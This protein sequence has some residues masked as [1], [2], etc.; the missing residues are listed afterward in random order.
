MMVGDILKYMPTATVGKVTD[1]RDRD[2][3][4]WVKLDNTN[5]YYDASLL[6]PA[7][8]SE[9]K[10]ISYKERER[11]AVNS[12]EGAETALEELRKSEEEVDIRDFTPSGG[13]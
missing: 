11:K 6:Q 4:V 7:D 8:A 10:E 2:G 13:G 12:R 3:R 5:L 9:Y 1:V